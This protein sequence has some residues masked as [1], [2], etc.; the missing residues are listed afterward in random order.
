MTA[1]TEQLR[2]LVNSYHPADLP[3]LSSALM[4]CLDLPV[5]TPAE[6]VIGEVAEITGVSAHTLRYYERIG[7]VD[8]RRDASGR[9]VYDP[10]AL[11]RVIFVTRLRSSDM[12][13]RDIA[14]YLTLVSQGEATVPA[15]LALMQA[16]RAAIQH[17][18]R[19]LEAAL[20]VIDY[21][22]ATYGGHC[23]P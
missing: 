18:L 17:R 3:P 11:A 10:E 14:R 8:V 6:L 1:G 19:Q 2:E 21:K 12:P 16:H 4:R 13:I 20:A 7:L 9:R 23:S 22:I 5:G 15:R